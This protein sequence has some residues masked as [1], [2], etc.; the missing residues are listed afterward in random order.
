MDR[1]I[2]EKI[3]EK[4]CVTPEEIQ[5]EMETALGTAAEKNTPLWVALF[6]SEKVPSYVEFCNKV[7][8]RI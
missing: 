8:E 2:L 7:A 6:G 5:K 3:A 4:Y 1:K